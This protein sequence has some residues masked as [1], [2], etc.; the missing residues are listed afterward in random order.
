MPGITGVDTRRLTRHLRDHGSMP[1]AFGTAAEPELRP[2][3]AAAPTT[4]GRDLVSSVTTPR[5][6]IRGDGPYRVVAYDFGIKE[7]MLGRLGALATVT[8]VPASTPAD[9]VLELGPDGVFLSNGPGDPAAL[10]AVDRRDPPAGGRAPCRSSASASAT[11]SW[12]PPLARPPTSSPSAITEGT[13]RCGG[14]PPAGSRSPRRTTTTR[15]PP[16]RSA[17]AEVTHV[18]L[19]DGVIEGLASTEAPAFSVQYHPEAGP[20]PH[21]ARY[22]F[23]EF[24]SL[25]DAHG[26]RRRRE[27]LMPRRSDLE[28]ILVIGSGPIVIGQ[29]CE[30]DY[31]GTQACRVLAEEGFRVVLANSNPATIMTDPGMADRT[32]VEPLD[33]DVLTAVIERERP[34]ALLPT[35]GGQTALNLTMALS[36]RGVLAANGVEVIGADP[37]AIA[38]AEDRERFK[39]AM[40][41]IGLSVPSSGFAHSLDEAMAIGASIGFPIMVRPSYILGGAGTGI[42]PTPTSSSA[43]PP[44]ASTPRRSARSWSSGRSP[45]RRSTSSRSCATT[46]TTA[47]S[48]APSRTSIPWAS[49]PATRSPSPRPRP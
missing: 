16:T 5:S 41:E 45:G 23:D 22:L 47:W 38:T 27:G 31:S 44:R 3:P 17:R 25:M 12:P 43:W 9:A 35:L 30:F 49:T 19:N 11:S 15:W 18:N 2:R 39:A 6:F 10:P 14:W 46:P 21:D 20:G 32:Y 40:E 28:S 1:C 42:A 33:P 34:D 29:A 13:T 8:V 26:A 36:E 37:E 4:D 48:S 7:A 24:R